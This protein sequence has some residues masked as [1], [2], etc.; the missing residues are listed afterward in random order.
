MSPLAVLASRADTPVDLLEALLQSEDNAVRLLV[1]WN[2]ATPTALLAEHAVDPR[3][4]ECDELFASGVMAG[5]ELQ[6]RAA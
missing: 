1:V 4:R 5:I 3:F 6:K 2:E